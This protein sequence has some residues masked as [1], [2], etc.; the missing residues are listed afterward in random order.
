MKR[1]H[2]SEDLYT[3]IPYIMLIVEIFKDLDQYFA[4]FLD[5]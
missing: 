1:K 3:K 5:L 4:I 2:L